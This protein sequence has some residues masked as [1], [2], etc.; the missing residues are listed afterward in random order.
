[1][2]IIY[3]LIGIGL[4]FLLAWFVGRFI[5]AGS[6]N[7]QDEYIPAIKLDKSVLCLNCETIFDIEQR[8]CPHC[9]STTYLNI[10]LALGDEATKG[11]V[12]AMFDR[13]LERWFKATA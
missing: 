12:A 8:A 1:M 13:K 4:S 9:C 11:R 3:I 10:G 5:W 6:G 2:I 7:N